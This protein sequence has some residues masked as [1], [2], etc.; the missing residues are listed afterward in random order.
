MDNVELENRLI[1]FAVM[2]NDIIES[3]PKTYMGTNLAKQMSRSGMSP[4]LNYAEAQ[5]AESRRDFIHKIK[6]VLKELRET[7]AGLKFAKAANFIKS[8]DK[9]K[10]TLSE[11]TELIAIFI[12]SVETATK[13]DQNSKKNNNNDENDDKE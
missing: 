5:S 1:A 13:N 7:S 10:K 8:E 12:K 6:I 3:L 11:N 9:F 2:V 4:F